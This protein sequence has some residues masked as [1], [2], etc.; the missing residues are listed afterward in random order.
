[1]TARDIIA[2]GASLGGLD[3]LITLVG[4]LPAGLNASLLI[5]LHSS[6]ESPLYLANIFGRCTPLNVEYGQ[7]G[8]SVESGH[9]YIAPPDHHMTVSQPGV[10]R[11]DDG[12]KVR[13]CRP[14]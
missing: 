2:V 8:R 4:G 13:F 1:M 10:V 12:P 14:L 6:P 7:H 11:L 9:V 3:A 5:V